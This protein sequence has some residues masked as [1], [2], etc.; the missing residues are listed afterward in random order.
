MHLNHT[1]RAD[2]RASANRPHLYPRLGEFPSAYHPVLPWQT[3]VFFSWHMG[4]SQGRDDGESSGQEIVSTDGTFRNRT[5]MLNDIGLSGRWESPGTEENVGWKTQ[6][7]GYEG[8]GGG[9]AITTHWAPTVKCARAFSSPTLLRHN[10]GKHV[11]CPGAP[12]VQR[13]GTRTDT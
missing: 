13:S 8:R 12:G 10:G 7:K 4:L 11:R 6:G 3:Y 5:R 2:W 1:V 9:G